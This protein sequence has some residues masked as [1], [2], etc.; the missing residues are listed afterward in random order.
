M[1]YFANRGIANKRAERQLKSDRD[2][3]NLLH[4]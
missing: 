1:I 4:H 3:V 2:N